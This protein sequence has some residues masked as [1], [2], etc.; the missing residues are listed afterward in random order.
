MAQQRADGGPD[1]SSGAAA[2][3]LWP[4][5]T[6]DPFAGTGEA[7]RN[8]ARLGLRITLTTGID[9]AMKTPADPS[10]GAVMPNGNTP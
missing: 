8:A 9:Q 5:T 6:L 4:E 2:R 1:R 3:P 7:I 10:S